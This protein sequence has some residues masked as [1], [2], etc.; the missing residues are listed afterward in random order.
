MLATCQQHFQ[1][2]FKLYDNLKANYEL[3]IGEKKKTPLSFN[4]FSAEHCNMFVQQQ[5]KYHKMTMD[6]EIWNSSRSV[7]EQTSPFANNTDAS[8]LKN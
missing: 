5:Q 8:Q 2:S 7:N 1:L 4:A 6:E 3:T